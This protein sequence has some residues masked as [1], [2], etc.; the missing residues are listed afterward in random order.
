[1]RVHIPAHLYKRD[2]IQK[3]LVKHQDKLQAIAKSVMKCCDGVDFNNV[4]YTEKG[5]KLEVKANKPVSLDI[6]PLHTKVI[7][8]TTNIIDSTMDLHLPKMWNRSLKNNKD[9]MHLN[10]HRLSF[11]EIVAEDKDLKVFTEVQKW[12]DI[13]Y[14]FDGETEALTFESKIWKE[15]HEFMHRKYAQGKVKQHSVGMFYIQLVFAVNNKEYGAEFEMWEKYLP[16]AVNPEVAEAKGYFWAVPEA[17]AIEGS[18]VP[19]GANFATP[20]LD[21]NMNKDF[22]VDPDVSHSTEK[23]QEQNDPPKKALIPYDY[24]IQQLKQIQQ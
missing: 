1:M 6:N 16:K 4:L 9:L 10:Q 5:E 7:I 3:Y 2:D 20:T 15:V 18:A 11:E 21:N 19:R 22:D 8:N 24:L 14:D 12:T 23:E 17:Q 13:G